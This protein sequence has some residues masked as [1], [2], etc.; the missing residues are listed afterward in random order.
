MAGI[1]KIET[2]GKYFVGQSDIVLFDK[3]ADLATATL[4]TLAGAK[5]LGNIH[6]DSTD[7]TG[8]EASVEG[9]KNEQG[10]TYYSITTKG[11]FGFSFFVP[12]T[13]EAVLTALL[14][15]SKIT[16]TMTSAA[17]V[18]ESVVYGSDG[19]N[20]IDAPIAI[21]NDSKDMTLV[22]PNAKIIVSVGMVDKVQGLNVTVMAQKV[23]TVN[24]KTLTWV[25][26]K[27]Q[28]EG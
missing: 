14:G 17:W 13:S 11:E 22:I 8:E 12:S 1:G 20:V 4:S 27:A 15:V 7:F 3:P 21:I 10:E 18:A 28:Y 19:S 25:H 6:L 16:D 24:L 2:V 26:G 5:S 23:D 9:L